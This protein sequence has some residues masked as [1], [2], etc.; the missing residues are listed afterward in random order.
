LARPAR[1]RKNDVIS[2]ALAFVGISGILEQSTDEDRAMIQDTIAEL[3]ARIANADPANAEQKRELLRLLTTLKAEIAGLPESHQDEA[4]SIA[5]F[6]RVSAHEAMRENRNPQLMQLSRDGLASSV[7]GLQES[8][9]TLVQ[10]VNR[11]CQT[12]ANLGI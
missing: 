3:E 6:A 7:A 11:I 8:H 2:L 1:P 9:P 12:L 4:Q 5:G 10:I